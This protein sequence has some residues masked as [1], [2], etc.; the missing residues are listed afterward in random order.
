MKGIISAFVATTVAVIATVA[1]A[2]A[3]GAVVVQNAVDS[4]ASVGPS[5]FKV[6]VAVAYDTAWGS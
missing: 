6:P 4:A 5:A 1:T 2:A 3:C